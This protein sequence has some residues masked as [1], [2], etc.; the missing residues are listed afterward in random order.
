MRVYLNSIGRSQR[1]DWEASPPPRPYQ[2]FPSAI[3]YTR[4][5]IDEVVFALQLWSPA[6][7]VIKRT[8]QVLLSYYNGS[9]IDTGPNAAL[10]DASAYPTLADTAA[11]TGFGNRAIPSEMTADDWWIDAWWHLTS[12][13]DEGI[14]QPADKWGRIVSYGLRR[15]RDLMG[16]RLPGGPSKYLAVLPMGLRTDRPSYGNAENVM[17]YFMRQFCALNGEAVDLPGITPINDFCVISSRAFYE[18]NDVHPGAFTTTYGSRE[19][20]LLLARRMGIAERSGPNP[21]IVAAWRTGTPNQIGFAV[22]H[23]A[24]TRIVPQKAGLTAA[25]V[26]DDVSRGLVSA[27]QWETAPLTDRTVRVRTFT[28]Q[29]VTIDASG[30]ANGITKIFATSRD[31]IPAT[32]IFLNYGKSWPGGSLLEAEAAGADGQYGWIMQDCSV[33]QTYNL[34]RSFLDLL[35]PPSTEPNGAY[36]IPVMTQFAIPVMAADPGTYNWTPVTLG[37]SITPAPATVTPGTVS[38]LTQSGG[39][40]LVRATFSATGDVQ[41]VECTLRSGS[42]V[43]QRRS[44]APAGGAGEVLFPNVAFATG[45]V[46]DYQPVLR[47]ATSAP[48]TV[49]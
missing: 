9:G 33:S 32:P 17:A 28:P 31:P 4:A 48:T 6:T 25:N 21:R 46:V 26:S 30:A 20:A 39:G 41:R 19:L 12:D 2:N 42:T 5:G 35:A 15:V 37:G 16:A 13:W 43:L 29:S 1:F 8:G 7:T 44:V 22:G 27:L 11:L 45:L 47:V 14:G 49:S 23:A 36:F 40:R 3:N 18:A 24:G 34:N 10:V 38:V